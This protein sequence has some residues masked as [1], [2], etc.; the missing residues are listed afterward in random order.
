MLVAW[1][2]LSSVFLT[3]FIIQQ[4]RQDDAL[5]QKAEV[6]TSDYISPIPLHYT[7]FLPVDNY[8]Q[9]FENNPVWQELQ[10]RTNIYFDF[11]S[12][13]NGQESKIQLDK[14]LTSG[15]YPDVILNTT[16]GYKGGYSKA[17]NDGVYID[18][19]PYIEDYA[20]N[21]YK[22]IQRYTL[23]QKELY[24]NTN[25]LP[26]F[27]EIY[28]LENSLPIVGGLS[29]RKDMLDAI[30]REVPTTIH[31]WTETLRKL[32]DLKGVKNPLIIGQHNG[33]NLTAE[34]L[35][36]Y[37]IGAS[38]VSLMNSAQQLFYPENGIMK[39]GAIET[40]YVEYLTLMNQWYHEGLL[41]EDFGMREVTDVIERAELIGKGEA[42]VNWQYSEWSGLYKDEEGKT[43]DMVAAPMPKLKK[44][45]EPVM[46]LISRKP[47][48]GEVVSITSE[49][50]NIIP[51]IQFFDYLYSDEAR[52]LLNYGIEGDTYK[53]V[54]GKPQYTD[55]V[56]SYKDGPY[57]G[58]GKY[59]NNHNAVMYD[60]IYTTQV[61]RQIY[62]QK[63]VAMKEVWIKSADLYYADYQLTAEENARL[64][65]IMDNISDYVTEYTVKAII[66]EKIIKSW[67]EYID[68]IKMMGIDEALEIMQ[69]A[70]NRKE[71]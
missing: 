69:Q 35:S 37:G 16:S 62:G 10:R 22:L 43:V 49:C 45:D 8:G 51:L 15:E 25:Q 42:A 4:S 70:Y 55:K 30:D 60:L 56:L 5:N 29:I 27:W 41:D 57:E 21:Y 11:I 38:P 3:Y 26:G 66:D 65:S 32:K 68:A 34:F 71:N 63:S 44:D 47:F 52:L 1:I 39:Y 40:G 2:I 67:D 33:V 48:V 61:Q 36:A 7:A 59:I 53:F 13:V 19:A 58:I 9:D 28:D 46:W 6:D 14:L 20:P 12:P 18:I 24:T 54:D 31:E 17:I 64:T 23:L 50:E